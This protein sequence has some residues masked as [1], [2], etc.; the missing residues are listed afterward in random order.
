MAVLYEK[1]AVPGLLRFHRQVASEVASS[2]TD[3]RVLDVGTGPAHLPVEL[4]RRSPNLQ[5]VGID[6]S[7]RMLRIAA[8]TA[9]QEAVH[10]AQA[11]VR[12][13]PFRDGTF[14]LVVST[15]SIHHWRD[16]A[17]GIRECLRVTAPGGRCWI[18]DLRTDVSAKSHAAFVTAGGL[19][20]LALGW[21][22][23][24][25]GVNPKNYESS[26]VASWLNGAAV[27]EVDVRPVYLKLNITK[28]SGW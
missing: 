6:L 22:F 24:F 25:H 23:K 7:R 13:L 26:S 10:F 5:L 8:S 1:V 3:G 11:D 9:Q 16:P 28:P 15:A 4:A 19:R 14:D 21:I 20:R 17:A 12:D 2:L 27:V 18:Y